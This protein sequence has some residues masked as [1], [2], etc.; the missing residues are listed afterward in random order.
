MAKTNVTFT[1]F[2]AKKLLGKAQTRPSLTDAEEAYPS[3]VSVPGGG[4]FAETIPREPGTNFYTLYSASVDAPATVERVYFD[5]VAISDGYYDADADSDDGGEP[6]QGFANH[7]YYLKLPSN[8]E[9]TSSNPLT[10]SGNFVNDKR[11]YLS[12]GGL[13]L[14]PPFTTDAGL[15]G[16]TGN[17]RYYVELYSGDPSNP[18]NKIS[19]TDAI[20]WQF[21]YYSGIIFIQDSASAPPVTASAYLY[22]G[23]YLDEKISDIADSAGAITVKDEGSNLTTALNSIDF[24]GSGVTATTSGNDVTVTIDAGAITALNNQAENRLVTIG[25]TTTEL[26]GEANLTFD[27]S[28]LILTGSSIFNGSLTSSNIVPLADEQYDLGQVELKYENLYAK[29]LDGGLMFTAIN[30]EGATI[31]RGQAVYVKG[32]S[33]QTPTIALAAADDASKMPVMGLVADGTSNDGNEVRIVTLGRLNGFDTSMFSAGDTLYVQTGSG[34]VSGSLTNLP[35]TGSGALIQN[36]ARV[37]KSDNSGQVRVGGAGRT[38]ATPNLDKGHIFIGN[39]SD[40]AVQDNTVFVS[41]SANRVG[42]N[43]TNPTHTLTVNGTVSASAY[44]GIET[45]ISYSRTEV[46]TTITASVSSTILGVTASSAVEIR[47]PSA[48]DYDAGQYFTVKDES[49]LANTNNITILASGSETIDGQA[50]IVLE[51]PYAAV[52]LYSNGTDKFFIY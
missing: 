46:T 30:D 6:T 12:R 38:N 15:P 14:V 50:S 40:Q 47:L 7:A 36:I 45:G 27:G 49:G 2:A 42:I 33:G 9:T 34:G 24:V 51:S 11:L 25:S 39:D 18:A 10:G 1:N 17:N 21:D 3:N 22:V 26:D 48:G 13:Q 19:S 20:D 44:V 8:Y 32:I 41:S 4:V 31:T 29:F 16:S 23:K 37:L 35:P 5:V 28:E 43:T 52:N